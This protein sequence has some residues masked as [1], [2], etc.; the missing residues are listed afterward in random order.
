MRKKYHLI[1]FA[2]L[3]GLF[4]LA[5]AY[6]VTG[7]IRESEQKTVLFSI[8]EQEKIAEDA[9]KREQ[10]KKDHLAERAERPFLIAN[11][12][13]RAK[14]AALEAERRAE[15]ARM[16]AERVEAERLATEALLAESSSTGPVEQDAIAPQPESSVSAQTY[17]GEFHSTAYA[18]GD[19]MTPG[20]VTANGTD[21]SS[22][23]YTPEGYRIIAVDP[24]VIPLNSIVQITIPGWPPFMAKACD[25]GSAIKGNKIDLL[26]SSIG[27]AYAFGHV[28]GI[29]VQI[30]F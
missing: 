1:V 15:E 27:E 11:E 9:A 28:Y 26:V 12:K 14:Q 25:T 24:S 30:L 18:I 7:K 16:E 21:V 4:F 3:L 19:G 20:T 2:I 17:I 29:S 6:H 23:I 8:S 22:T 10:L 5:S 13:E